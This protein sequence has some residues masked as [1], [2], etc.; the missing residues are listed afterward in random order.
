MT[1]GQCKKI[2]IKWFN[3]IIFVTAKYVCCGEMLQ[4]VVSLLYSIMAYNT[5][6][7]TGY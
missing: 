5:F 2:N 4:R 3:M 1:R 7:T 6:K